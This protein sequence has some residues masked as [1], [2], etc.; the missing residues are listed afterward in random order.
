MTF[1]NSIVVKTSLSK[2]AF[3]VCCLCL[4]FKPALACAPLNERLGISIC[5][6]GTPWETRK[7]EGDMHL[8]YN[9]PEDFAARVI[10]YDGGTND[11][12]DSVRSARIMSN[13]DREETDDFALLKMGQVTSGNVVYATRVSRDDISFIHVNTVSVGPTKTMRISTW[14]RGD[15]M[16]ERDQEMHM[17][18]G[19][20]LTS[21]P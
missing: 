21:A 15:K 4:P 2:I 13:F 19:K 10:F 1:L 12:L 6:E 18:F 17:S 11:G 20:L 14:R 5:I 9:R 16:T 8:F 3:L 7:D